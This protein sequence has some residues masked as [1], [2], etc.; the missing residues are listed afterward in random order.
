MLFIYFF[1]TAKYY[2]NQLSIWLA[3]VEISKVK[4]FV[5]LTVA[6]TIRSGTQNLLA[7]RDLRTLT[8]KRETFVSRAKIKWLHS[9]Y[10]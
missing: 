9:S 4:S 3:F 5:E 8:Y 10:G 7:V 2:A 1:Q 6:P